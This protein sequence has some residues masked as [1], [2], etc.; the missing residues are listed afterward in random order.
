[1]APFANVPR[2]MSWC[3]RPIVFAMCS[4]AAG[5]CSAAV[6]V[7]HI[8]SRPVGGLNPDGANPAAG[9]VLSGGLLCGTTFN[10]G[11]QGAGTAFYLA[12]DT[13]GFNAFRAFTNSPDGGN[14]RGELTF[15]RTQLF[16]TTFGGGSNQVGTVF[17]GQTNGSVTI[18]RSFASLSAD[19]ATNTGGATPMALLAVSGSTIFGTTTA[20]G[21]AGNGTIFSINTNGSGFA[22]LHNFTALDCVAGT[23]ADGATPAGGLVLSG[24]TLYGTTSAGGAAGNGTIFSIATSGADFAT[25]HSFST[26][27]PAGATNAEGAIPMSG[28]L[29]TNNVLYGT[30]LA[31]GLGGNGTVFSLETNG[32]AFTVLHHFSATAPVS[33][34]NSDGASPFAAPAL[35]GS[36]L[37]GTAAAGGASSTGTLFSVNTNGTQFQTLYSFSPLDAATGTNADGATPIGGLLLLGNSLYGTTFSGGPGGVGVAFAFHLSYP[38]ALITNAVLNEDRTVTLSFLG[39]PGSLNIVQAAATLNSPVAWQ[40]VSTNI[41]DAEGAWQ[42]TDT[43]LL[44]ARFYRSYAP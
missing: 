30:T 13:T 12:P 36:F 41:A 16:G 38:P 1:M 22:V 7:Q 4:F 26:M 25:L 44:A 9:L 39:G 23:N 18:I 37:Y 17:G 11:L 5:P 14:P 19:H 3:A 20:G 29:L 28:L 34:T 8:F 6:I 27:D 31:G 33:G 40:N 15:T 32:G 35:A 42:F 43:N 10:G 21:A 2:L 24:A